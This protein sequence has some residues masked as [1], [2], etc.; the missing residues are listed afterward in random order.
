[1]TS[2]QLLLAAVNGR[3]VVAVRV[4]LLQLGR[5]NLLLNAASSATM[6][7]SCLALTM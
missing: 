1:M 5:L 3:V 7:G 4:R 2:S 6:L